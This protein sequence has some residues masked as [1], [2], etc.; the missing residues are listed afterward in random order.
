MLEDSKFAPLKDDHP[1]FGPP[2]MMLMGLSHSEFLK[3]QE[4]LHNMQGD[5]LKVI[6]YT[7]DMLEGTLWSAINSSQPG[8][9][10]LKG[11][12]GVPRICFLSGLTGE[13]LLM[14]VRAYQDSKMEPVAFAAMVPNNAQKPMK[15][16][17]E[18]VLDD[19]NRLTKA[20]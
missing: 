16:L 9:T 10:E 7:D 3:V 15:Q 19:H 8:P 11:A 13:E 18:E 12:I 14:F 5:F 6:I 4:L 1:A 20:S 17:I 2:A